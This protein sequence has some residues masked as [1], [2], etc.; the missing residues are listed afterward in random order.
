MADTVSEPGA[1]GEQLRLVVDI[2]DAPLLH[3]YVTQMYDLA[4]LNQYALGRVFQAVELSSTVGRLDS[5]AVQQYLDNPPIRVR[6]STLSSPWTIIL[7]HVETS[8]P[9]FWIGAGA[10]SL[11]ATAGRLLQLLQ[12]NDKRIRDRDEHNLAMEERRVELEHRRSMSSFE[13]M[14]RY[15]RFVAE[16][17]Q[18]DPEALIGT[19]SPAVAADTVRMAA[20]G[21][22]EIQEIGIRELEPGLADRGDSE[23]S[24]REPE[25]T[26]LEPEIREPEGEFREPELGLPEW[27]QPGWDEP[28]MGD[29]G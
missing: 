13:V 15:D 29:P 22:G 23:P 27:R 7:Q 26:W 4:I 17:F 9:F 3:E 24:F 10:L 5:E 14:E 8:S 11:A 21:L 18:V 1:Q 19:D 16:R 2:G 12:Q 20:S 25:A 28:E 6:R